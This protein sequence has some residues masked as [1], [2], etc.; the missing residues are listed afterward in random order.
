MQKFRLAALFVT[1]IAVVVGPLMLASSERQDGPAIAF[2]DYPPIEPRGY[3]WHRAAKAPVIDGK[4]SDEAWQTAAWSE[5]FVDIE[6]D[7]KPLPRQRTRMKMLWDDQYLYIGAQLEETHVWA[8]HTKHD[9]IIFDD[10]D[11]EVFIDPDC[12]SQYY[13]ELEINALNTTW[14]LLL[15]K[16]YKDKGKAIN[17]WEIP[18]LKTAVH[19]DGTVNDPRDLDRGWSV[20][21]AWPWASLKEISD[22]PVP[23]RDGDQWRINFSR[24]EWQHEIVDGRYR[25]IKGKKEDNWVWSPQGAVDMHRPERWG[26]VQFS[27]ARPGSVTLRKDPTGDVRYLLHRVLY[28][29]R[30]FRKARGKWAERLSD[31]KLTGPSF[32]GVKL[33]TT[34][35]SFEASSP[36]P[37][38]EGTPRRW[39]INSDAR[40]WAE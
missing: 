40:I 19:V 33:E 25:K 30:D 16:P 13:A 29:Q 3:V 26:I 8:T 32:D 22:V 35:T 7:K 23:P 15:T 27:T 34:S 11:F 6:G 9:S 31:L 20:E 24:V 39:H 2:T 36:A 5:D 4:L 12:D 28:A 1:F 37:G 17:A 38:A 21:I 18:G 14:D 10:N